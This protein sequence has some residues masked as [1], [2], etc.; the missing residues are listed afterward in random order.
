MDLL[1]IFGTGNPILFIVFVE[2]TAVCW[3]YGAERF[4]DD[5]ERMLGTRPGKFWIVCWKYIS[6]TFI[7]VSSL[8]IGPFFIGLFLSGPFLYIFYASELSLPHVKKKK[9]YV[10]V[11][12]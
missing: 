12:H 11:W 5:I 1:N 7:F 3:F 4:A 2:A 9:A 6:P 8:L 10:S